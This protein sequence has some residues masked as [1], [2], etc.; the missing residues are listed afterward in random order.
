ML[1][2]QSRNI[3][4]FSLLLNNFLLSSSYSSFYS[5]LIRIMERSEAEGQEVSVPQG[6][7]STA[8]GNEFRQRVASRHRHGTVTQWLRTDEIWESDVSRG[9]VCR[10]RE[11]W[12][13][14]LTKWGFAT[15][16]HECTSHFNSEPHSTNFYTPSWIL[17]LLN[18]P[19]TN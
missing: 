15:K 16:H 8:P 7:T 3:A 9:S 19:F 5:G 10:Q 4:I 18:I 14:W 12:A 13:D 11:R 2:C 1:E 6:R 17:L